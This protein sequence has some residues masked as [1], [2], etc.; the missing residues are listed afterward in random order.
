MSVK[1]LIIEGNVTRFAFCTPD[2][3]ALAVE[4][5]GKDVIWSVVRFSIRWHVAGGRLS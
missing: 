4:E 5:L 1:R 2:L 3:P